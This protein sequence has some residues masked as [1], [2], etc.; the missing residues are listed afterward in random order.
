MKKFFASLMAVLVACLPFAGLAYESPI[1]AA[2]DQGAL[3]TTQV[4]LTPG[5]LPGADEAA[6]TIYTDLFSALVLEGSSQKST[7]GAMDSFALKLQGEEALT[8]KTVEKE[9]ELYVISSLLGDQVLTFNVQTVGEDVLRLLS[10]LTGEP[11]ENLV[12]FTLNGVSMSPEAGEAALM[13]L[14]EKVAASLGAGIQNLAAKAQITQETVTSDLHD[15]ADTTAKITLTMDDFADLWDA[16]VDGIM[17]AEAF[18]ATVAQQGVTTEAGDVYTGQEALAY[19]EGQLRQVSQTL[20]ETKQTFQVTYWYADGQMV[21]LKLTGADEA[22]ADGQTMTYYRK[23]VDE[24]VN[25]SL[26]W[27]ITAQGETLTLKGQYAAAPEG[28]NAELVMAM[29]GEPVTLTYVRNA[30]GFTAAITNGQETYSLIFAKEDGDS[31]LNWSLKAIGNDG[32]TETEYVAL[33][34]Q[35]Q[36]FGL[37]DIAQEKTSLALA[38]GGVN[39]G[40]LHID[41]TAAK[42]E[43]LPTFVSLRDMTDEQLTLWAQDTANTAVTSL[44]TLLQH[45]PESVTSALFE[46]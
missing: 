45:L 10:L 26:D 42:Q 9:G 35:V 30:D 20:R 39:M 15:T 33:T 41:R 4:Y 21:A 6:Q 7:N 12:N 5:V 38:L 11:A 34:Y 37:G 2:Y 23:T 36:G 24:T 8:F 3:L 43:A 44:F 28:V 17:S 1:D 18:M 25:H 16:L 31:A 22:A 46:N 29:G 19:Y 27:A 13:D 32:V 40:T 14:V